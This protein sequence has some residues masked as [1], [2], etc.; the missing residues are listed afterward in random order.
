MRLAKVWWFLY[1]ALQSDATDGIMPENQV[2]TLRCRCPGQ[3]VG[4]TGEREQ[5]PACPILI[6]VKKL[7]W[8]FSDT[9]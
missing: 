6:K 2:P 1:I 3:R 9:R 8:E 4:S 5:T 7:D